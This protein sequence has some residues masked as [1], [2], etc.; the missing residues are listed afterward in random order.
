MRNSMSRLLSGIVRT[1]F[2]VGML[3][4]VSHASAAAEKPP[5]E[6]LTVLGFEGAFNLPVWIAQKNGY[7][8]RQGL[9]VK[10]E[11][12]KGSVELVNRLQANTGQLA[13]TSI[14]NVIAYASGQGETDSGTAADLVAFMGGDHGLLSLVAR[15]EV[16]T[17]AGL[18]R[19]SVAVDA[20]TTGFAFVAQEL[21]ASE[22]LQADAVD[23]L[24]A[25][26]TGSRYRALIA[27]K[28]DATLLRSPFEYLAEQ[29]G[30]RVLMR[31]QSVL[32]KYLG[33]VGAVRRKWA[34]EHATA[35]EGFVTAYHQALNW[36]AKPGN[37]EAALVLL[38]TNFPELSA[39]DA[40]KVYGDL[41]NPAY[42]LI[43]TLEIDPDELATV[44]RLRAKRT[45]AQVRNSA[46]PPVDLT[47]LR[48]A[49]ARADWQSF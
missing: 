19:R 2:A 45:N 35:L 33:T 34:E 30:F 42:G 10:L 21:L 5:L 46:K 29:K 41:R 18:E 1:A 20:M 48:R 16:R 49:Q 43:P 44:Q 9:T 3:T 31:A 17:V 32:P 39:D 25:G 47:Y 11:Y 14:D 7:F 22:G 24:A 37:R 26:G 4:A 27:G 38:S 8:E 12:P 6:T 13:L 23:W 15:P 36:F 40:R 28:F